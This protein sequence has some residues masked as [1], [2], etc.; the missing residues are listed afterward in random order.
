MYK[1]LVIVSKHI[2]DRRARYSVIGTSLVWASF[3][4]PHDKWT[5]F[6]KDFKMYDKFNK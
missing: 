3:K 6:E 5:E 4:R 1:A 2:Y